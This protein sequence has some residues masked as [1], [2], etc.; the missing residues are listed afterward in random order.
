ALPSE[1][2]ADKVEAEF[3]KGVLTVTLPKPASAIKT[4]KK[5]QIKAS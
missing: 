1:V 3:K 4:S 5:I 2:E